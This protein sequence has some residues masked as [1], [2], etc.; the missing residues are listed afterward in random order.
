MTPGGLE[1]LWKKS[2]GKIPHL[3][4]DGLRRL[5]A[6]ARTCASDTPTRF[7]GVFDSRHTVRG[8]EVIHCFNFGNTTVKFPWQADALNFGHRTPL[9]ITQS[10]TVKPKKS[11]RSILHTLEIPFLVFEIEGSTLAAERLQSGCVL[12]ARGDG[13]MVREREL[14]FPAGVEPPVEAV[15]Y[16]FLLRRLAVSLEPLDSVPCPCC[17]GEPFGRARVRLPEPMLL[18]PGW[19]VLMLEKNRW[20]WAVV[21][22]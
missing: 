7:W 12:A 17:G 14:V 2:R 11:F 21:A 5:A 1:K 6:L 18:E 22:A 19:I 8:M 10:G 3:T 20:M 13:R 15:L 16:Y 4:A 9:V